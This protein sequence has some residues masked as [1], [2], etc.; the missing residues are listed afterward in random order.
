MAKPRFLTPADIPQEDVC[1]GLVLPNSRDWFGVFSEALSQTIYPWNYT[2]VHETDLTPE[3]A[4]EEA[5]ERYVAWLSA[6]CGAA[7]AGCLLP[8]SQKVWRRN[9]TTHKLEY[10]EEEVWVVPTGE[11]AIPDPPVRP[12]VSDAAKICQASANAEYV[13]HQLWLEVLEMY[14]NELIPAV[15]LVDFQVSI[16]L[17]I[18]SAF[19]PPL[20][21]ITAIEEAAFFAFYRIMDYLTENMWDDT[22]SNLLI[23]LFQSHASVV[24]GAVWFNWEEISDAIW[25][26]AFTGGAYVLQATQI[27]YLVGV[28]GSEGLNYA[29]GTTGVVDAVCGC[30]TWGRQWTSDAMLNGAEWRQ[31][32]GN[33][34]GSNQ[35]VEAGAWPSLY[36]SVQCTIQVPASTQLTSVD[37]WYYSAS[38]GGTVYFWFTNGPTPWVKMGGADAAPYVINDHLWA[39]ASG[40]FATNDWHVYPISK[41]G[42]G[43]MTLTFT[44]RSGWSSAY[45]ER[46]RIRG[47]GPCPFVTGVAV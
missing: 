36:A 40:N 41:P 35:L 7:T 19:Y 20:A 10:L 47:T 43:L 46:I 3:A 16:G 44:M 12:E 28:I 23:C 4:A 21:A 37:C 29:G 32:Q 25:T 24:D 6:E 45:I 1:R 11:E 38:G 17:I 13:L 30:G 18:A 8:N 9:P 27:S 5:Y 26:R 14:E 34:N 2:Q 39:Y 33:R 31:I 42:S 22:W 15:A